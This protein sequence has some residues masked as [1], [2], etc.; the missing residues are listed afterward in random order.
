LKRIE[1]N[2]LLAIATAIPMILVVMT[3]S[4]FGEPGQEV[5][6]VVM[7]VLCTVAF[8]ALNSIMARRMGRV[9]PALIHPDAPE[10]VMWSAVFPLIVMICAAIPFFF[11]G[12]DYGLLLIIAA[13]LFGGTVESAIKAHKAR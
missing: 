6:Y 1:P 10:T 9:R 3:A 7:A 2:L 13:I 4:L 12:H 5:K 8:V 11:P